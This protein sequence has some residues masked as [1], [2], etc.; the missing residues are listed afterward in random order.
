MAV[1]FRQAGKISGDGTAGMRGITLVEMMVAV[2]VFA[3]VVAMALEMSLLASRATTDTVNRSVLEGEAEQTAVR[4]IESLSACTKLWSYTDTHFVVFSVPVDNDANGTVLDKGNMSTGLLPNIEWGA[5]AED[6]S[7]PIPG[8][9]IVYF[10]GG[11]GATDPETGQLGT[12]RTI[13]ES[14]E[15][16]D[17]NGDGDMNDSFDVGTI[18]RRIAGATPAVIPVSGPNVIQRS[19]VSN[20]GKC[21]K[22]DNCTL[23]C[24]SGKIFYLD[25]SYV[26]H[27]NLWMMKI[28]ESRRPVLVHAHQQVYLRNQE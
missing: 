24:I 14:V 20:Y 28:P 22:H 23:N 16:M 1:M 18:C 3:V 6:L 17:I 8:G 10:F 7:A 12:F 25:G 4:L 13:V 15:R 9:E 11:Q 21:I 2:A 26:M 19:G 27:V 5:A